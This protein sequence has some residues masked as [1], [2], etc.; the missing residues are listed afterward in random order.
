MAEFGGSMVAIVTPFK[1]GEIDLATFARLVT[2][3][4]DSGTSAIVVCGTTGE[5][6]TLR[7]E[8]REQICRCA[9]EVAGGRVPV[10][11]G[12]GT[13]ATWSSVDLTQA[14]VGWGV[15]GL[16]VVTPYYNKPNRSGM[17]AHYERVTRA[18]DLPVVVYNVPGR[19]GQNLGA[20][21]ILELAG[22]PGIAGVKE[23]S[24][25]LEQ[26]AT[27][28]AGRPEGFRVFSGDDALAPLP[29]PGL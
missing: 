27:V 25:D 5:A 22:I 11:Y 2:W 21:L 29:K 14:A 26:I 4:I 6:A 15:D 10:I 20:E 1:S 8:E 17:L 7:F 13:N 16:L 28:L 3:Q 12:S 18:T 9:L 24:A 23:A 19:T